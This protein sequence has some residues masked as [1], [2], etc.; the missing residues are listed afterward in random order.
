MTASAPKEFDCK[1][2]LDCQADWPHTTKNYEGKGL[3]E[4]TETQGNP[5]EMW[6]RLFNITI[7]PFGPSGDIVRLSQNKVALLDLKSQQ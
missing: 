4:R 3:R 7:S 6:Q 2:P 1:K 5:E